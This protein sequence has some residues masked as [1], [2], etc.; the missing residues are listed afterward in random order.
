MKLT[1]NKRPDEQL[2]RKKIFIASNCLAE[3]SGKGSFIDYLMHMGEGFVLRF[4][5]RQISIMEGGGCKNL[6]KVHCIVCEWLLVFM[7]VM[8][9][10]LRVNCQEGYAHMRSIYVLS[11]TLDVTKFE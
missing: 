10:Q 2:L 3:G 5:I 7:V 11:V 1:L 4:M 8:L 6:P 9:V